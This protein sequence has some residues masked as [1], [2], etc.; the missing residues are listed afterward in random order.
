MRVFLFS[1]ILYLMGVVAVLYFKPRLMFTEDGRWKEFGLNS[2]TRTP[3]P[4]WAFVVSFAFVCFLFAKLVIRPETILAA[5]IALATSTGHDEESLVA[6][7]AAPAAPKKK[8]KK[9]KKEE[10]DSSSSSSDEDIK[11]GNSVPYSTAGTMKPGYYKLDTKR[12][13]RNGA[14][15][16][17]YMGQEP[18]SDEE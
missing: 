5:N 3:F 6:A 8:A 16:Y 7:A 11:P 17:I 12:A 13:L 18:P 15:R 4:F 2:E 9:V 1:V 14:P 10:E